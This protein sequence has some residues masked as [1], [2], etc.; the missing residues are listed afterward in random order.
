[1]KSDI[2]TDPAAD[3]HLRILGHSLA[4]HLPVRTLHLVSRTH[5]HTRLTGHRTTHSHRSHPS[6][7]T[8]RHCINHR[9]AGLRR[10]LHVPHPLYDATS[11]IQMLVVYLSLMVE[12]S[13]PSLDSQISLKF[14]AQKQNA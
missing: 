5:R 8:R 6:L 2:S 10:L 1:M 13:C 12:C 4:S 3:L 7:R 11:L 9:L 14:P